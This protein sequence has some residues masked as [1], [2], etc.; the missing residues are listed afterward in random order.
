MLMTFIKYR[1]S[2]LIN[3]LFALASVLLLNACISSAPKKQ[4][5]APVAPQAQAAYQRAVVAMKSGQTK[6]AFRLFNSVS[7]KYPGFSGPQINIG[8]IHLKKNR[9]KKAEAAFKK[10]IQIN[11]DNAV[12]YNLL[13]VVYRRSGKFIEA[14]EA[15]QKALSKD[16]EYA[17]A[18][19]NLGVLYDIYM[20]DIKRA[21]HHYEEY[22]K[23]TKTADKRVAKWI[24]DLNRRNKTAKTSQA[25]IKGRTRG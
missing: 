24:V 15:Y 14:K 2:A 4:N 16:P 18:H 12:S 20:D 11:R 9:L 13:G 6:R 1:N 23:Y 17:N 21:L 7:K 19:L 5:L 3:I 25:N 10:A 22:Q 8:L